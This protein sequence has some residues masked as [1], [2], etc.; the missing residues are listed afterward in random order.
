[1]F[2][3]N[4]FTFSREFMVFFWNLSDPGST[5]CEQ[6][7]TIQMAG[8]ADVQRGA[9]EESPEEDQTLYLYLW[10][11]PRRTAH[12]TSGMCFFFGG[13]SSNL[14]IYIYIYPLKKINMRM[15]K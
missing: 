3:L 11:M 14:Y 10:T 5:I 8:Y 1:M 15:E 13:A 7:V 6:H 2:A 12:S 9:A 4:V